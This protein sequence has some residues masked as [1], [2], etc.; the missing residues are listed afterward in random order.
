[1]LQ[2]LKNVKTHRR[3]NVVAPKKLARLLSN[4]FSTKLSVGYRL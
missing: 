2:F 3:K 1:M 4:N